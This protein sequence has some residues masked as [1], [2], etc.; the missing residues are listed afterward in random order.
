M[1]QVQLNNSEEIIKN[2]KKAKIGLW[3]GGILCF[4]SLSI[5]VIGYI[6][7]VTSESFKQPGGIMGGLPLL[8][9]TITFLIPSFVIGSTSIL[10]GILKLKNV[11]DA[12]SI[13][14]LC[15]VCFILIVFIIIALFLTLTIT[16]SSSSGS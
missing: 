3:T 2:K 14:V 7:L 8:A 9:V 6:L 5:F 12:G 16:G 4:L 15:L 1:N 10:Y 11:K 13:S